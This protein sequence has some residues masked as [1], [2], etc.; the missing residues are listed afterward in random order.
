MDSVSCY[1]YQ[2]LCHGYDKA[3]NWIKVLQLD[4]TK[5]P[6]MSYAIVRPS[7]NNMI[8]PAC[9]LCVC[10]FVMLSSH[11]FSVR[12]LAIIPLLPLF[13]YMYIPKL[14]E[15]RML[16]QAAFIHSSELQLGFRTL[17]CLELNFS[18]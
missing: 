11:W 15:G 16:V 2:Q 5:F 18:Y 12:C 4:T 8:I 17:T 9:M 10:A 14:G 13:P 1:F 6:K 3:A 7:H